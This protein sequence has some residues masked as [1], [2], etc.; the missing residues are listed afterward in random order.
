MIGFLRGILLEK[1]PSNLT[2][3][4][5]GIGYEVQIP[6]NSFYRLPQ[7]NQELS[8]HIHFVVREDGQ[9]LYGFV[10]KEQRTLFR[11]LIKVNGVGP[12]MALAILSSMEPDIFIRH[13][14]NNDPNALEHI[15]GIGAKTARRLIIEMKDK[16]SE[17]KNT[18]TLVN[19]KL[20]A[21]IN[22]AISALVALGYKP[23]EARR[24]LMKH[25]EKELSSE[26]LVRLALKEIE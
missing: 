2:L 14:L 16:V 8:L 9:F 3:E 21:A 7:V 13:V 22:D 15:P 19:V 24:A 5:N 11:S 6:T 12:K 25:K 20:G 1:E 23:H 17:W 18:S 10:D 4:V 26:E